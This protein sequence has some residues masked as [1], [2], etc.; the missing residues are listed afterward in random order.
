MVASSDLRDKPPTLLLTSERPRHDALLHLL[1]T[2]AADIEWLDTSVYQ[3]REVGIHSAPL[4]GQ[5]PRSAYDL[6]QQS[7]LRHAN[8]TR[9]WAQ[10]CSRTRSLRAADA[11]KDH[12]Q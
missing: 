12:D 10:V 1:H 8:D 2:T 4:D 11:R 9:R 6:Q 3:H 5:T 7:Y